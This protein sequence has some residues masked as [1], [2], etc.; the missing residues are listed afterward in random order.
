MPDRFGDG[1]LVGLKQPGV[2]VLRPARL[3]SRHSDAVP[4]ADAIAG[5]NWLMSL[6]GGF[7]VIARE[8]SEAR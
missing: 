2:P 6:D 5:F 8:C 7:A 4:A 1:L 3:T